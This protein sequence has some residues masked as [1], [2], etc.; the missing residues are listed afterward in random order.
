M[1]DL[2]PVLCGP[3]LIISKAETAEEVIK[4]RTELL[5]EF[6]IWYSEG[7][8]LALASHN[9]TTV[10]IIYDVFL[11]DLSARIYAQKAR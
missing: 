3:P 2:I 6:F 10:C 7:S 8:L 4:L 9:N 5:Q 11:H 1:F